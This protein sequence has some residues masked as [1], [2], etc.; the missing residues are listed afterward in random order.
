MLKVNLKGVEFVWDCF[1]V[2]QLATIHIYVEFEGHDLAA[3]LFIYVEFH[4]T[5][6][7][8]ITAEA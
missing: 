3:I 5:R 4:P 1:N 2:Q 7:V 8:T 6:V